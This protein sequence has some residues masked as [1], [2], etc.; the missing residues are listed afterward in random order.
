MDLET[1]G[2]ETNLDLPAEFDSANYVPLQ[3]WG[4]TTTSVDLHRSSNSALM[5]DLDLEQNLDPEWSVES[6]KVPGDSEQWYWLELVPA[7]NSA[8]RVTR[9][10]LEQSVV[11]HFREPEELN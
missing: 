8:E 5:P 11:L 4:P 2:I 9:H 7:M 3:T 10:S 1:L 6:G